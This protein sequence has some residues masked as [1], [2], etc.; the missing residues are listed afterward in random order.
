MKRTFLALMM[1]VVVLSVT[2]CGGGGGDDDRTLVTREI[3]SDP[4]VDGYIRVDGSGSLQV[5]R[6][7][8]SL[9]AGVSP[10]TLD[11]FRAFLDFPLDTIPLNAIIQ[12]A[13]L[14]IRIR[15][16]LAPAGNIPMQIELVSFPPPLQAEDYDSAPLT[17]TP[18][19]FP[20]FFSDIGEFV[21]INVTSLMKEA[22][23]RGLS[24]FQ[25]RILQQ[26]GPAPPGLIEIDD[27]NA[28]APLLTVTYF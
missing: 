4:T 24:N 15:N 16:V 28:N 20:I 14:E 21:S 26:F 13:T 23:A 25:I 27:T 10:S 5:T 1:L 22:Q 18:V 7:V 6:A 3:F 9:F 11:E 2:G 17:I 8:T 19:V 12:T